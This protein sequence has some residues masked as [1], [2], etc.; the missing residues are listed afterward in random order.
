[1]QYQLKNIRELIQ[2][3]MYLMTASELLSKIKIRLFWAI[4][5]PD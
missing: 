5:R 3:V 4:V 1:M 2:S